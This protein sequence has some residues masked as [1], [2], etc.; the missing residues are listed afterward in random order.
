[1]N[2]VLGPFDDVRGT[3]RPE[4]AAKRHKGPDSDANANANFTKP[5]KRIGS[6]SSHASETASAVAKRWKTLDDDRSA[7]NPFR[8]WEVNDDDDFIPESVS[9]VDGGHAANA[10]DPNAPGAVPGA[11]LTVTER[12]LRE[13]RDPGAEDCVCCNARFG[14]S[15]P[16]KDEARAK[17]YRLYLDMLVLGADLRIVAKQ[18]SRYHNMYVHAKNVRNG[19]PSTEWSPAQ[20]LRHIE[21]HLRDPVINSVT[22]I[23]TLKTHTQQMSDLV[24]TKD[25]VTGK[26]KVNSNNFRNMILAMKQAGQEHRTLTSLLETHRR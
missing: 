18:V 17:E 3:T 10:A 7:P 6:A 1:M 11:D 25:G 23:R 5:C 26:L 16:V 19:K 8:G 20:V 21:C 24:Y 14:G 4:P 22:N 9:V 13:A 2:S 15:I 12:E